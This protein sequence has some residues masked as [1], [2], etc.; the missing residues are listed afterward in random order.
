VLILNKESREGKQMQLEGLLF[1]ARDKAD[2]SKIFPPLNPNGCRRLD[3][4]QGL[5]TCVSG[6]IASIRKH[7]EETGNTA[8]LDLLDYPEQSG[9]A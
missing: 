5:L 4:I 2:W 7:A 8:V 6:R 3:E 9:K 1:E